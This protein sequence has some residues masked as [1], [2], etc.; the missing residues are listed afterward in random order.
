MVKK[1]EPMVTW[2]PGCS[3]RID[4][5]IPLLHEAS[6]AGVTAIGILSLIGSDK[7]FR[8][9]SKQVSQD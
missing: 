7:N 8:K 2:T 5:P 6:V 4:N 3:G 1:E 9:L